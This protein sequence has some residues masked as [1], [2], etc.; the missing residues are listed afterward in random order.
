MTRSQHRVPHASVVAAEGVR[1]DEGRLEAL[2][3]HVQP[4]LEQPH[5]LLRQCGCPC[6]LQVP[7]A[8]PVASA[9]YALWKP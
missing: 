8:P 2:Q 5:L 1:P 7:A 9:A 4:L 6:A 3:R